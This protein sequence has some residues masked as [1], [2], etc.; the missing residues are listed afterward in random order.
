MAVDASIDREK[1]L[2]A[3]SRMLKD[4]L[5]WLTLLAALKIRNLCWRYRK[6]RKQLLYS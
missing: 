2:V 3:V 4:Q 6:H 1:L 5:R